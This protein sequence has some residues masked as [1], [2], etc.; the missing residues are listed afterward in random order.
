[1]KLST[2]FGKKPNPVE[3]ELAAYARIAEVE[4]SGHPSPAAIRGLC[5]S[6][7]IDGPKGKHACLVHE[8]MYARLQHFV[9]KSS[10]YARSSG[11]W[12]SCTRRRGLF[13]LVRLSELVY[14]RSPG[15]ADVFN[16]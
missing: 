12:T 6:F 15:G 13:I 5:D 11:L 3:R 4:R 1:M 7:E 9:S 8:P 10:V 2:V 16:S 14:W